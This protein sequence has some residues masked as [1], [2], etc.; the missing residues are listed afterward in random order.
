MKKLLNILANTVL[1]FFMLLFLAVIMVPHFTG[2]T[3]EPILSGSMEPQIKTGALVAISKTNPETIREGDIISFWVKGTDLPVCHRV[4]KIVKTETG[5]GFITKGDANEEADSWVVGPH[6]VIGEL[7][8]NLT[9]VG[10]M[11]QFIKTSG[12]FMWLLV[13]PAGVIAFLEA[14]KIF[15]ASQTKRKRPTL[16]R[17]Q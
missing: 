7:T 8:H 16:L 4:I 6:D 13:A 17:P 12:G 9:G 11:T 2:L 5:Y 3:I 1:A 10:Y 14:R 15:A